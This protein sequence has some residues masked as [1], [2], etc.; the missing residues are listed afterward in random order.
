[1]QDAWSPFLGGPLSF[2]RSSLSQPTQWSRAQLSARRLDPP[3]S[4]ADACGEADGA[5]LASADSGVYRS[6]RLWATSYDGTPVPVSLVWRDGAAATAATATTDA[7][8]AAFDAAAPRPLL[9]EVYGCYG[10]C[11]D[12]LPFDASLRPLLDRGAVVAVAHVRGG[13]ELGAQ[14]HAAGS[15]LQK[16]NSLLDTIACVEFLTQTTKGDAEARAEPAAVSGWRT[17]RGGAGRVPRLDA[18][19]VALR[20]ASAGAVA[21]CGALN[22]RPELFCGAQVDVP[23][24]DVLTSMGD[25][26]IPLVQHEY[27]EWG[28]PSSQHVYF[29][30][31]SYS[32]YDN[33]RSDVPYPP[34][35]VTAGLHDPRVQYWEPAKYVARL[36]LQSA[37]GS[38][39]ALLHTELAAGHYGAAG[40]WEAPLRRKAAA[41]AFLLHCWGLVPSGDSSM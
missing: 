27:D 14:W 39:P 22:L 31:R 30:Q 21:A 20:A 6:A 13:G 7:T 41:C 19:R 17:G 40:G 29:Y 8:D 1:M 16:R 37:Q 2:S 26:S 24:V 32:P 11:S 4:A 34:L 38:G 23:F 9:V 18:S 10:H 12:R 36:R 28:C 3:G 5:V 35:L 25:A 15:A 33:L